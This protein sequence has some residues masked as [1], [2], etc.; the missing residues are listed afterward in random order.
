M[1]KIRVS[2]SRF[3]RELNKWVRYINSNPFDVLYI[4]RNK[5]DMSVFISQEN[6]EQIND[7]LTGILKCQN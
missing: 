4:T 2:Q 3:I 1:N 5:K 7:K 6:Y